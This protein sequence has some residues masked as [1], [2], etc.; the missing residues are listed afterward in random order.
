MTRDMDL[1]VGVDDITRCIYD[2][3]RG[4]R[5]IWKTQITRASH[6]EPV[7]DGRW[8]AGMRPVDGPVLGPFKNRT[9][10]VGTA[11]GASGPHSPTGRLNCFLY[12]AGVMHMKLPY[13]CVKS[14]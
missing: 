9:E 8:W 14:L 2:Q 10:A 7:R 6:V 12:L 13:R 11:R 3:S 4:L 1:V 5:E